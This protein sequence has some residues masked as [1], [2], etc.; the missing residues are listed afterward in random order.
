MISWDCEKQTHAHRSSFSTP[1]SVGMIQLQCQN[2]YSCPSRWICL[3]LLITFA[4]VLKCTAGISCEIRFA[5]Y[6]RRDIGNS[7]SPAMVIWPLEQL[8]VD[9]LMVVIC[10]ESVLDCFICLYKSI[11]RHLYYRQSGAVNILDVSSVLSI[12]N[13]KKKQKMLFKLVPTIDI[14]KSNLWIL[15]VWLV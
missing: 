6:F 10:Y 15:S 4:V 5:L 8:C 2:C 14:N 9:I 7:V 1:D 13:A 12:S 3:I 11:I